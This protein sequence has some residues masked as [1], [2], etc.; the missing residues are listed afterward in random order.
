MV[1]MRHD[2]PRAPA[3]ER[4]LGVAGAAALV[5]GAVAICGSPAALWSYAQSLGDTLW[6][7]AV[8]LVS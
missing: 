4:Y 2:R 7:L 3:A 6:S 1:E 8:G 5:V